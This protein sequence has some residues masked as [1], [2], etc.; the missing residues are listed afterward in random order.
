MEY[1]NSCGYAIDLG[2]EFDY[3]GEVLCEECWGDMRESNGE[4]VY[5]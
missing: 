5:Y 2:A 4:V 3:G 1:C